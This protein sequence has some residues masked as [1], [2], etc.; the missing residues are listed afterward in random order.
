[1]SGSASGLALFRRK[2]QSQALI[3]APS[4]D[5]IEPDTAPKIPEQVEIKCELSPEELEKYI[6]LI[7]DTLY[8]NYK[9]KTEYLCHI[10]RKLG[11]KEYN[12]QSLFDF[13]EKTSEYMGKKRGDKKNEFHLSKCEWNYID[14][15]AFIPPRIIKKIS[16]IRN[17]F[18]NPED[19]VFTIMTFYE[20]THQVWFG[21]YFL[22]VRCDVS[23]KKDN[24]RKGLIIDAWRG[25]T[26]SDEESKI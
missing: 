17:N 21:F 2:N 13:I 23:K 4:M 14:Y 7:G 3:K 19:L 12:E 20:Y 18:T 24:N 15:D 11:Y 8:Q 9:I 6:E 22:N 26:F 25:P 10:L 16:E 1:M 5:L